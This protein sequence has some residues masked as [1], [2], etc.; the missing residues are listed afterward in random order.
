MPMIYPGRTA[1]VRKERFSVEGLTLLR[2][3]ECKKPLG[4]TDGGK[5]FK[6]CESC[7]R[8]VLLAKTES[9]E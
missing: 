3:P 6:R 2:Y 1:K 5:F 9:E 8:W 7:G 4:E